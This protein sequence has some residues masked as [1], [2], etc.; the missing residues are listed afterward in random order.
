MYVLRMAFFV[1]AVVVSSAG[2]C[3]V[4]ASHVTTEPVTDIEL[5][6]V[7]ISGI[8]LSDWTCYSFA[9]TRG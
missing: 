4:V 9:A 7:A 3:V 1:I 5:T 8:L 2:S 6:F